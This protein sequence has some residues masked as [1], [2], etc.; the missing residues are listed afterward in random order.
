MKSDIEIAQEVELIPI[1]Q[2]GASIGIPEEKLEMYGKYKA[3]VEVDPSLLD[4]SK[5][6]LILVSA[7]TPNKAGVGKTTVSVSLAQG[8]NKIGKKAVVALREASLGPCFGMK[9]GATGGGYSQV[10]P[11]S[12]INLHF[13]GDFHA[14][15]TANNMLA[16]LIDN[17]RF[18]NKGTPQDLKHVLWRRVMD[19]NDRSLRYIVSG[20]NGQTNGIPTE[21][22]FDIT[23]ASEIMAILCLSN[24]LEDLRN[25][26]NNILIGYDYDNKAI[27]VRDLGFAGP[28][29]VLLKDAIKPN[30]VQTTEGG[31]AFVHGGPFA[32]IAHGCNSIMATKTAMHYADYVVTE[33]GFGS[34]LGAEKFLNIKCRAAGIAPIATVLVAT[35]QSLK[36]HGGVDE[37]LIKLPNAE[38][39]TNGL[40]NLER[41]LEILKNFGQSVL[42]AF[43]KFGFDT[44][45]EIEMIRSWCI[46]HGA[47]FAINNGFAEGGAGAE[48]L[49]QK[50]VEMIETNPSKPINH[51]YELE[52]SIEEKL[53]KVVNK[54]YKGI[55]VSFSKQAQLMLNRIHRLGFDH[56]PVCVA[57]TQYS[58]S[59]DASHTG[60]AEGFI[61]H[62]EDLKINSG[63]GFIVAVAGEMMRMPG[64]PRY[65]Q[66]LH[67]DLIDGE[68]VGLS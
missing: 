36:L 44:E 54:I 35:S 55:S 9:G 15:T 58:F 19:V 53:T 39:I 7:I 38:G 3:K 56:F 57:K 43:N 21:T 29:M 32:N 49:A 2:I 6:N 11:M 68:I 37:K 62:I 28:L 16:A 59:E 40:K 64:L 51:T 42:I 31:A 20:L 10:L 26:I 48:L 5:S 60:V 8:L 14:I 33:A 66:A 4:C 18:F 27:F 30:L 67:I 22:G 45:E 46:E 63:A 65:P 47:S 25:R 23:A 1:Q 34:D 24:D 61:L 52:D 50:V 41:H 13:T 12:D 17:Y